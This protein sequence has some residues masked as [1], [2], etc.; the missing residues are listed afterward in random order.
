M[1]VTV[2][3]LTILQLVI[4]GYRYTESLTCLPKINIQGSQARC[5]P[6]THV[7][8]SPYLW[9]RQFFRLPI[10]GA[11]WQRD[12]AKC[13]LLWER[14]P[15]HMLVTIVVKVSSEVAVLLRRFAT[16]VRG[17]WSQESDSELGLS[18]TETSRRGGAGGSDH[19]WVSDWWS[20]VVQCQWWVS[21]MLCVHISRL[22]AVN[23]LYT[24]PAASLHFYV[25]V[26]RVR[27][28]YVSI[29]ASPFYFFE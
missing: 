18:A 26:L 3:N 4:V 11:I 12:S 19:W 10:A 20:T 29:N 7:I 2:H 28:Q 24:A 23:L 9:G 1:L 14:L 27:L 5:F 16:G 25:F 21:V 8:A 6:G 13:T 22:L 17:D 15:T